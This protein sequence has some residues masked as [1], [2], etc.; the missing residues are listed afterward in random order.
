VLAGER[1]CESVLLLG[2]C[3]LSAIP[4][5]GPFAPKLQVSEGEGKS[6]NRVLTDQVPGAGV[7]PGGSF[8]IIKLL[9]P[10]R[11]IRIVQWQCHWLSRGEAADRD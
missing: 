1:E 9:R 10:A 6:R 2:M 4:A 7:A 11:Y 3:R 5:E 8:V